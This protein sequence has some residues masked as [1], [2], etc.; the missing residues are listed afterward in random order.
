MSEPYVGQIIMFAGD[1]APLGWALCDGSVIPIAGNEAL[2]SLIGTTYGGDGEV[3]FGLPDLRGRAPVSQ[4]QG[5]GL[6]NYSFNQAFGVETVA[7]AGHQLPSHAHTVSAV[8]QPG[9]FNAPGAKVMLSALGGDHPQ[10]P[11]Y[12]KIGAG[13]VLNKASVS[14]TGGGQ[15]HSNMQ[16]YQVVN[17]CI[18]LIGVV[19]PRG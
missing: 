5:R 13:V 11:I 4:G 3:T 1:F 15:P 17:Y 2:F 10:V 18:A 19:P 14:S 6:S 9:T 12:S 8:N 16:P 7:L